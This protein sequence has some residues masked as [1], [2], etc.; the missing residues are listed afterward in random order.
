MTV[1]GRRNCSTAPAQCFFV[2]DVF[3]VSGAGLRGA[4]PD[5][6][7]DGVPDDIDNCPTVP[8]PDQADSNL[9]DIGDA[10]ETPSLQHST[11]NSLQANVDGTTSVTGKAVAVAQEP[12][13]AEQLTDIVQSRVI[14]KLT[15]SAAQLA[16]NLVGSLVASGAVPPEQA[17]NL[18]NSIGGVDTTPPVTTAIASPAPNANGWNNTN[19]TVNFNAVDEPGGSGVKQINVLLSGAQRG[20]TVIQGEV[21]SVTITLEVTTTISYSSVDNAENQETP[22][23]ILIRIDRTPPVASATVS[24]SPNVNSWNNTNVH[25]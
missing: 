12:S 23:I 17:N 16:S 9:N 5:Q 13:L 7:G 8:N 11:A 25:R 14:N 2:N 6:D 3:A 1:F 20:T 24:P 15:S 21:G 18:L 10:C 4:V 22:K 19:V